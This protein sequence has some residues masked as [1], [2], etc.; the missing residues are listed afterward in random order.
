M[1]KHHPSIELLKSYVEGTLTASLSA[2]I[3]IHIEMCSECRDIVAQLTEQRAEH[4][5]KN[6]R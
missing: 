1:I 4:S 5:L 2:G 3:T 6:F